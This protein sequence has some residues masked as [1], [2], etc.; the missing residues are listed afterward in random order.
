[1]LGLGTLEGREVPDRAARTV[2]DTERGGFFCQPFAAEWHRYGAVFGRHWYRLDK[3]QPGAIKGLH[4]RLQHFASVDEPPEGFAYFPWQE[5][6]AYDA[7]EVRQ[8][9]PSLLVTSTWE[10]KKRP[11]YFSYGDFNPEWPYQ[12]MNVRDERFIKFWIKSY[13]RNQ[14]LRQGVQNSWVGLDNGTFL[15]S[16]YGVR[17]DS[18]RYIKGT[19]WDAPYPKDDAEWVEANLFMLRK[20]REWAPDIVL[21]MNEIGLSE[22]SRHRLPEFLETLGAVVREDFWYYAGGNDEWHRGAFFELAS[23]IQNNAKTGKPEIWQLQVPRGDDT[24]LRRSFVAFLIF[25]GAN[26]FFGPVDRDS[27]EI[28]PAL[29]AAMRNQLGRPVGECQYVQEK[30]EPKGYGTY[31]R[32][33]EGGI[34]YLNWSGSGKTYLMPQGRTCYDRAGQAVDAIHVDD[35]SGD[36][37]RF[38]PGERLSWP[39]I[40]PRLSGCMTGPVQV[41]LE[42]D[43][44]FGNK[45]ELRYTIDGS[46]PTIDAEPYNGKI[47]LRESCTVKAAAF[48]SGALTSFTNTAAYKITSLLPFVEVHLSADSG[49]EFL[50]RDF[51]LAK[52]SRLS[53]ERV[54]IGYRVT[55]GTAIRGVDYLL[56]GTSVVFRPGEQYA[57]FPIQVLDD[58]DVEGDETIEISLESPVNAQLGR[59]ITYTYSIDDN[60]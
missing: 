32:E 29:W 33:C 45:F 58:S 40:H 42:I 56:N 26:F 38:A 47:T 16:L 30:S 59:C 27:V 22:E 25:G 15:M 43:P 31:T 10:G 41:A 50:G 12:A 3:M 39:S 60:D 57:S 19:P 6:S 48:R 14:M 2:Y 34:C 13:A 5:F 37:V 17:D 11:L 20:L 55:G 18:G 46:E 54:T 21:A 1:M 23:R 35:R 53:A 44:R 8:G 28:D 51:V 49:S 52:L 24:L 7:D 4:G 36:Y 9:R